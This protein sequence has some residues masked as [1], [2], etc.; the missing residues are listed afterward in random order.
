MAEVV[1]RVP[2]GISAAGHRYNAYILFFSKSKTALGRYLS[3]FQPAEIKYRKHT[4]PSV[5]HAYQAA[6]FLFAEMDSKDQKQETVKLFKSLA[7]DGTR[8]GY[9]AEQA[10]SFGGK[11]GWK[12]LGLKLDVR[13]WGQVERNIMEKLL[14]S[15]MRHDKLF[16]QIIRKAQK[17]HVALLHNDRAAAKSFWG[18]AFNPQNRTEFRGHNTLGTIM[19]NL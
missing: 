18:G 14:K 16:R 7:N 4:F 9:T 19:M 3:N 2:A 8:S 11:G 5:E 13:R 17:E 15:R 1:H 6:K 10:K 12:K